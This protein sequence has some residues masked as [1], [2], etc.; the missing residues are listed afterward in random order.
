MNRTLCLIATLA[1]SS[2]A[3]SLPV[4]S[5]TL[6]LGRLNE[7]VTGNP[8][9]GAEVGLVRES[10][11]RTTPPGTSV[12][13]DQMTLT[14]MDGTYAFYID[15][16]DPS[17]EEF[18]VFSMASAGYNQIF[19]GVDS[20]LPRPFPEDY[21]ELG[22]V[23]LDGRVDNSNVDFVLEP[24]RI[25]RLEIDLW[26]TSIVFNQ[27]HRIRVD[28]TS[29][30]TSRWEPNPNTGEPFRQHTRLLNARNTIHCGGETPSRIL[31]P[32]VR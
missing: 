8:F 13:P 28:V 25:Y 26:G 32:V 24:G 15:P 20:T 6:T 31:L 30:A 21:R 10:V 4:R 9:V 27:G 19:G 14:W 11:V 17:Y 23:V 3:L 7:S 22:V 1:L 12:V 18:Y 2:S 16:T 5:D 29:S